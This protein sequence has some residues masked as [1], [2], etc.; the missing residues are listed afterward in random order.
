MKLLIALI[1]LLVAG[2]SSAQT[3][4]V[5]I[6]AFDYT[7]T[8]GLVFKSDN[9]SGPDR[10]ETTFRLNL[11][12]AQNWEQYVGLM[13]KARAFINRQDVEYGANDS[14]ETSW[15]AAGGLLYNLN[16][17]NIKDSIFFSVMLGLERATYEIG[18]TEDQSGFNIF[19]DL[20]GG[21]RWDLGQYSVVNIAYAP[22]LSLTLKRYGGDIRDDYFRSG[23]EVK[24][25][26]LRFDILF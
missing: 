9:A 25:N 21:K 19:T 3:K 10:D 4:L 18:S 7:Y 11:N 20:E 1:A 13:W 23:T 22:T 17:E 14:L 15:G 16:A 2:I 6:D 12:Y 5:S 24:I 26:F 8:G